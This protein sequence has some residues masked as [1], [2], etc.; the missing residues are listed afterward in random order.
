[1]F[2]ILPSHPQATFKIT[3]E[4]FFFTN[5]W[6][7]L[8]VLLNPHRKNQECDSPAHFSRLNMI[9]SFSFLVQS[10][11][12]AE[13]AGSIQR[14]NIYCREK[15]SAKLKRLTLKKKMTKAESAINL[16]RARR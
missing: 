5:L 9:I 10:S 1:M 8:T 14:K 15:S 11:R 4:P 13:R 6:F 2:A 7:S 3:R 16:K 12:S